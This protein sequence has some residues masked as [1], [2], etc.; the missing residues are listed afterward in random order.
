MTVAITYNQP[1]QTFTIT[2]SAGANG[3]ISPSGVTTVNLGGSQT[4]T[5][6][7]N[8]GFAV[9]NVLVNNVSV[10]AV[11]TY[12]FSSVNTPQTISVTFMVAPLVLTSITVTPTSA[13]VV[14]GS[15]QQFTAVGNDQNGTPLVTQPTFT[16][17]SSDTTIATVDTTGLATGVAA[18]GPVTITATSGTISGTASLTVTAS[19]VLTTITVAPAT[20]S[21]V[22]GATQ[23]FTATALDQFGVALATQPTFTWTSSD[24]TVATID[25]AGLATGVTAGGP[26]TITATSGTF[27]GT[28]SLTVT[29]AIIPAISS[30]T[31]NGLGQNVAFNPNIPASV[32]I[33]LNANEPVK[34]SRINILNSLNTVV[35]YFTDTTAFVTTS[36]KVWNGKN[37]GSVAV[38]PDGVYTLQVNI[39]DATGAIVNGLNLTP[40]T[41]TVDT[42]APTI[43]APA[44]ITQAVGSTVVLGTPVATDNLSTP[45]VTNNAPTTF[46]VGV[47]IVTWTATDAAGNSATA[48]QT[49]TMVSATPI[50]TSI[51]VA[52][53]TAS[54]LIG[55]TQQFTAVAKDQFGVALTTQ[56]TFAWT[57][58]NLPVAT[59]SA[60]GLATGVTAGGPVTITA[61]SGT[62]SGTAS[63]TVTAGNFGSTGTPTVN[64]D[65]TISETIPGVEQAMTTAGAGTVTVD[66]QSGTTVTG[67]A[68]WNGNITLPVS[69]T[70]FTLTPDSGNTASS[71]EAIEMGAGDMHL[72]FDKAVKLTFAGQAGKFVGWSQAG[73]FHPITSV[74]DSATNPTLA[75]G[76]DCKIDVGADLVVWTKHFSAFVVY[77]QTSATPAPTGNSGLGGG[78]GSSGGSYVPPATTSVGQV[79]GASTGPISGCG[80]RTTGFSVTTGMS[81]VG[82]SGEQFSGCDTR[83]TGYSVTTGQSCVGNPETTSTSGQE[84]GSFQFTLLLKNGSTG[85]EVMQLQEVLNSLGYN[86]G[87]ADGKFGA[88]TKA[89]VVKFQIANGLKGDGIVGALTRADLN[90]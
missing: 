33:V 66:I 48:T 51:T 61:T 1:V 42:T 80:D 13:S 60:T 49:V 15:T 84:N 39:N 4:Y 31:L 53:T 69:T 41:I 70:S 17:T 77:T 40:Y 79:L 30:Y 10:G 72:T 85:S 83:N 82:N 89:A 47:T 21:V 87:T 88:K 55:A 54:V 19:P 63:L 68:T 24:T 56:P 29:T 44:N 34:F 16:W 58:S 14:A 71:I 74:C 8:T 50:L 35:R 36:T 25:T 46:P 3:T 75:A 57:S 23:Q 86:L 65:G 81:C 37:A 62:I 18:G 73:T 26:I 64:P 43:T 9:A 78:G 5:I 22:I 28:A 32:S 67:P 59:V 6:T 52:P 12:T 2:A 38:V 20:A 45:V 11:T 27:S 90:R 76:A 7:P